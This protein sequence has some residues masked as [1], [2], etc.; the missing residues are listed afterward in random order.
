MITL[1]N[2]NTATNI[3]VLKKKQRA[4]QKRKLSLEEINTLIA[5][6]ELY[7]LARNAFNNLYLSEPF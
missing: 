3:N 2:K 5:F 1:I 7:T 6:Y 4:C